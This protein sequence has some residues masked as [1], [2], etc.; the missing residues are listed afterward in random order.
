MSYRA[1]RRHPRSEFEFPRH[2]RH[3]EATLNRP[4]VMRVESMTATQQPAAS[5]N[6]EPSHPEARGSCRQLTRLPNYSSTTSSPRSQS[7]GADR[8]KSL[9][10]A[11]AATA[12]S[13]TRRSRYA[14]VSR[15]A[16]LFCPPTSVRRK[17][18][19]WKRYVRSSWSNPSSV[20]IV[21]CRSWTCTLSSTAFKPIS[22]V[23]P[24]T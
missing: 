18:R 23:A 2:D 9:S 20:R 8:L 7:G 17:S 1:A 10:R 12:G 24:M 3:A 16:R 14:A 21:A 22:S 19:P 6:G 13:L 11:E 5:P 4:A 15:A